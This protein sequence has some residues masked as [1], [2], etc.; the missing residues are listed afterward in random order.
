MESNRWFGLTAM[1]PQFPTDR[2]RLAGAQP[3]VLAV[4][5]RTMKPNFQAL[6][7]ACVGMFLG[8]FATLS[9]PVLRP[10]AIVVQ[11]ADL[12]REFVKVRSEPQQS[13]THLT[14]ISTGQRALLGVYFTHKSQQDVNALVWNGVY[15]QRIVR[16]MAG[17]RI[18][19]EGHALGPATL[20]KDPSVT[21]H[22]F[23]LLFDSFTEAEA[24]ASAMREEVEDV[25]A[26]MAKNRRLWM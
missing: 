17:S 11:I 7:A 9:Q 10:E 16:I 8:V 3:D 14:V 15:T 4:L 13:S 25:I 21:R 24:A 26:R 19:A 23:L 6:F 12:D 2:Q 5:P 1:S 22:G 18:V 20:E